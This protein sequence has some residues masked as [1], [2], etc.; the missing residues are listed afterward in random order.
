MLLPHKKPNMFGL[1][2][3]QTND[4][5]TITEC[6]V[7]EDDWHSATKDVILPDGRKGFYV[8]EEN[9]KTKEYNPKNEKHCLVSTSFNFLKAKLQEILDIEIDKLKNEIQYLE[10]KKQKKVREFQNISIQ[11]WTRTQVNI[12]QKELDRVASEN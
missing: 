8:V 4:N 5:F 2:Y 3:D 11:K 9:S 12:L 6:Y 7:Y 1:F 10:S